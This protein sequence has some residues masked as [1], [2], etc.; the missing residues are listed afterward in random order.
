MVGV[1]ACLFVEERVTEIFCDSFV[2]NT[3]AIAANIEEVDHQMQDTLVAASVGF[4]G[5]LLQNPNPTPAKLR[6]WASEL[7][8]S[9]LEIFTKTGYMKGRMVVS[10][11]DLDDK[12]QAFYHDHNLTSDEE[13]STVNDYDIKYE[14]FRYDSSYPGSASQATMVVWHKDLG[15]WLNTTFVSNDMENILK[16]YLKIYS[17]LLSVSI[18]SPSGQIMFRAGSDIAKV[19]KV[20][21]VNE[22]KNKAIS[23]SAETVISYI[24]SF[25]KIY[26]LESFKTRHKALLNDNAEYFYVLDAVFSKAELNHQILV[27][28]IFLV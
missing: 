15:L 26:T 1:A 28:R 27:T 11:L 4:R 23:V 24:L 18:A 3:R 17:H 10:T 12:Q 22:Y 5:L 7:K 14:P 13:A 8:V 2:S 16:K 9:G 21:M 6:Q 25:G 19:N 20:E